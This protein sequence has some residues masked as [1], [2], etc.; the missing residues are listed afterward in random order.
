MGF[1]S[2][3]FKKN[4]R[5]AN[6]VPRD[7][8]GM[9]KRFEI[10]AERIDQMQKIEASEKYRRKIYRRFYSGYPEMPFISQD[11]E[12]NTDWID[13]EF[14]SLVPFENM[15][16]YDDGLLPGHA[17]MLYWIR[18]Y[19]SGRR[20][21]AYFEYDYGI[22]FMKER[23]FLKDRKYLDEYYKVTAL[24]E[25]AIQRHLNV[26]EK[27]HPKPS[28]TSKTPV[29]FTNA[30]QSARSIP[31]DMAPGTVNVPDSDLNLIREEFEI[32]N[33][34]VSE[35]IKL[36]HLNVILKIDYSS[37]LFGDNFTY[38]EC[39]PYTKTGRAS[40]YPLTLHYT[41]CDHNKEILH[42]DYFG[43]LRYLNNGQIGAAR[44]IFWNSNRG[45]I[46]TIGTVKNIL[47]IKKVE[48]S[49]PNGA[50]WKVAYKLES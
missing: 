45:H 8:Y 10:P 12:Y 25:S 14:V 50:G 46:V 21:P 16:R 43:E 20:I 42:Q 6:N 17:Y 28:Y 47:A 24:G 2:K 36:A 35:A 39:N 11:R 31:L 18:K 5:T 4:E 29:G 19:K 9:I 48:K 7:K 27:R 3:V 38:Y 1:F 26:I 49:M 34:L 30:G 22:E 37:L 44:L 32:I 33:S 40:K 13:Q 15:T 23:E 41:Y